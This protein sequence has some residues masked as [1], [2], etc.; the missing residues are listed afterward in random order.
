VLP[1]K[2]FEHARDEVAFAR[3]I[4]ALLLAARLKVAEERKTDA[5]RLVVGARDD[6]PRE[7]SA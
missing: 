2:D 1:E 7:K 3:S 5:Y 6:A 4:T